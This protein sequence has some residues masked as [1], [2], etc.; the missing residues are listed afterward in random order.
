MNRLNK[1]G[2][3]DD[4]RRR[5]GGGL[6]GLDY[7]GA[8]G[9]IAFHIND[10]VQEIRVYGVGCLPDDENR[11]KIVGRT[12]QVAQCRIAVDKIR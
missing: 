9:Y 6:P 1:P 5:R 8:L 10:A 2:K 3:A 11:I 12:M 7:P 4:R